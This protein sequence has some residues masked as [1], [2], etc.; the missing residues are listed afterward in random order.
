MDDYEQP[1][2]YD[3]DLTWRKQQD[4]ERQR[5][6]TEKG[7]E[8]KFPAKGG[9]DFAIVPA[10]NHVAI[11][12]VIVDLGM[13][14]GSA[15]FP[16]PKHQVYVRFELPGE[17]IEYEKD[18][19][20]LKGPMS[21][22]RT[23]TASM[24]AKASLRKFIESWFGKPFPSDEAAEDFD[25]SKVLGRRCLL[26]VT[27]TDKGEKTYANIQAATPLPKGMKSDEAQHNASLFF[28][29]NSPDQT[30]FDALPKWLK[31]KVEKRLDDKPDEPFN[32]ELPPLH[33]DS[34]VPF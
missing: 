28:D 33:D 8:M 17:I 6:E 3:D 29:L 15:A 30:A 34:D 21:I 22:G 31:E 27:H 11:C 10:G 26:N 20:K 18:G 24:N 9:A 4:D 1:Q 12:N 14:P 5:Y 2:I 23:F 7:N 32:D 16:Q 19:E 25:F 13:Q